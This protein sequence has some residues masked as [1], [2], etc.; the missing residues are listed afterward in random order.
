MLSAIV[1]VSENGAIG[2]DGDLP[3]RLSADLK[4]FKEITMGHHM[5]M[6]RKTWESIGRPLPGRTSVVVTHQAEYD[7][8]DGV[9]VADSFDAAL[10]LCGTDDEVFVIGGAALFELALPRAQRLYLTVVHAEVDGD[11]W[12]PH[13]DL[14][15]W[16]LVREERVEADEKNEYASTFKLLERPLGG[17]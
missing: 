9:L 14:D 16:T 17:C 4:R 7:V 2:I 15:E 11:V 3:W 5:V 8:P 10:E 13:V 12:M 6:G 1:A